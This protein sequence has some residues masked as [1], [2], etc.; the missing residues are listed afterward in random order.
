[1]T[2]E[3]QTILGQVELNGASVGV[4]LR[5]A[6]VDG[7]TELAGRFHRTMID[8]DT[9][10]AEQMAAVNAHL[11]AMLNEAGKPDPYPA[12][13]DDDLLKI[14]AMRQ[15]AATPSLSIGPGRNPG[16]SSERPNGPGGESPSSD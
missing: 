8:A 11:A 4:R 3:K 6:L 7:K 10:V 1:M 9:S 13:S 5:L 12:V 16:G 2:I 15:V 14:E